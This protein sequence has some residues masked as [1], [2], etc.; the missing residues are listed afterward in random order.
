MKKKFV[1]FVFLILIPLCNVL[2]LEGD[3]LQGFD[4][5]NNGNGMCTIDGWMMSHKSDNSNYTFHACD[6]SGN[7]CTE[8]TRNNNESRTNMNTEATEGEI[9]NY[10]N[11]GV[12]QTIPCS[13]TNLIIKNGNTIVSDGKLVDKNSTENGIKIAGTN[14][15]LRNSSGQRTNG[16]YAHFTTGSVFN[17]VTPPTTAL[18]DK[19]DVAT[20]YCV[21][22]SNKTTTKDGHTYYVPGTDAT[23]CVFDSCAS[24]TDKNNNFVIEPPKEEE[25]GECGGK[26]GFGGCTMNNGVISSCGGSVTSTC[27]NG[28]YTTGRVYSPSS[29]AG[30]TLIDEINCKSASCSYTQK[31]VFILSVFLDKSK[32]YNAGTYFE[33]PALSYNVTSDVEV[34]SGSCPTWQYRC[35][36]SGSF[37]NPLEC[38]RSYDDCNCSRVEYSVCKG[39]IKNGKCTAD[40]KTESYYACDYTYITSFQSNQCNNPGTA[41]SRCNSEIF[42]ISNGASANVNDGSAAK[43]SSDSNTIKNSNVYKLPFNT[44]GNRVLQNVAYVKKSNGYVCYDNLNCNLS[45]KKLYNI[46]NNVHFIPLDYPTGNY[47]VNFEAGFT[48]TSYGSRYNVSFDVVNNKQC[49]VDVINKYKVDKGDDGIKGLCSSKPCGYGFI[50]RPIKLAVPFPNSSLDGNGNRIIGENWYKWIKEEMENSDILKRLFDT[51]TES[52]KYVVTLDNAMISRIRSYNKDNKY[53]NESI[54]V[55]GS[56]DFFTKNEAGICGLGN[57]STTLC[58]VK[59]NYYGLGLNKIW[60]AS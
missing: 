30:C 47:Y 17:M 23:K 59:G 38:S 33:N 37:G 48:I 8:L 6:A 36:G 11:I 46:Y 52:P 1:L 25:N 14:C 53:I 49:S 24:L 50:Y 42:T 55:D 29:Y 58:N 56:S 44:L 39:T 32:I 57:N 18:T 54:S 12:N 22:V 2:A 34:I 9:F 60:G 28:T 13:Y 16:D 5:Q 35:N 51:Y 43:F 40:Y 26:G 27:S 3:L 45:D 19:G 31:D 7:N 15:D 41:I 4:V 21:G 20:M 10:N